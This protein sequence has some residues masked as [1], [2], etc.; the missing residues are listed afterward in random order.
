[1][2]AGT[3]A[4]SRSRTSCWSCCSTCSSPPATPA[5]TTWPTSAGSWPAWSPWAC[6]TRPGR[7]TG[8][9]RRP[10]W[11]GPSWPGSPWPCSGWP[12]TR[13]A[14]ASP[15]WGP[16]RAVVGVHR[17]LVGPGP[18]IQGVAHAD[19]VGVGQGEQDRQPG[20]QPELDHQAGQDQPAALEQPEE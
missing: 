12:T 8:A 14:A 16:E 9:S 4:R 20:Q 19:Q 11:P 2:A 6:T 3:G 7:A 17:L 15:A 18:E 1:G 5:S 13:P 10:P